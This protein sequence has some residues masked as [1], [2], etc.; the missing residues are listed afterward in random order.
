MK[1]WPNQPLHRY[2]E[3]PAQQQEKRDIVA[4]ETKHSIAKMSSSAASVN[5]EFI[6]NNIEELVDED[7]DDYIYYQNLKYAPRECSESR[8][9]Q[10]TQQPLKPIP[11]TW[12]WKWDSEVSKKQKKK[13]PEE[14]EIIHS[15]G[16]GE[17]FF[18]PGN[19][20]NKAPI[21]TY[22]RKNSTNAALSRAT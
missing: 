9:I 13:S 16:N 3:R 20:P 1:R 8:M 6:D 19:D 11:Y 5:I 17:S 15:N 14:R 12:I 22:Y 10:E 7:D 18:Y 4:A 21:F 2:I